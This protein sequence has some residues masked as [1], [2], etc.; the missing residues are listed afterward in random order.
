MDLR[1]VRKRLGEGVGHGGIGAKPRHHRRNG[2][3][4]FVGRLDGSCNLL[5]QAASAPIPEYRRCPGEIPERRRVALEV[6]PRDAAAMHLA[7]GQ[8]PLADMAAG[9]CE[10]AVGRQALVIEQHL[11]NRDPRA[12]RRAYLEATMVRITNIN[13]AVSETKSS[14][15]N[16]TRSLVQ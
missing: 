8:T 4:H 12:E 15:E 7:V 5:F 14:S 9:A 16:C 6:A 13:L 3:R 2:L 10:A 1:L 11:A